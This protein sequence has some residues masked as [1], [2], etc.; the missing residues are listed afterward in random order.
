[1][2]HHKIKFEK[3]AHFYSLGEPSPKVNYFWLVTHGYGQLA[4]HIIRKFESFDTEEHF[5]VAPEALNRFYWDM[6]KGI[7]GA[8]WMTKQDRLEEI[9]DYSNFLTTV[10]DTF[11]AQLSPSVKIIFLGFSQG[12]ATQVRWILRGRPHFHHLILWGGILPEDIDYVNDF[13]F[14][15][16]LSNKKLHFING[17]AD[18]FVTPDKV[19][20]HLNFAKSQN[21]DLQ[22]VPFE[23]KHEILVPVLEQ[24]FKEN[25]ETA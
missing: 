7:V 8:S 6:R 5:I 23:G 9:E 4:S 20:W 15:E 14:S 3:T 17:D 13:P 22:Y 19:E 2:H 21:I 24:F 25:I 16:Y 18:E 1:M 10:Y 11:V 12:S